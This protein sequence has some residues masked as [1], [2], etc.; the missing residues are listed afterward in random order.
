MKTDAVLRQK[1]IKAC[2]YIEES[3]ELPP[4]SAV[5]RQAALSPVY[6]QKVFTKALGV[7]P[8]HYA[9]AVRF[10]R[11]RSGLKKGGD[12]GR[13]LYDAGFGGSSRLYEFA[14]RYL[15]MTPRAYQ[16]KGRG[17]EITY[18]LANSP[19]GWLLVAATPKGICFVRPGNDKKK[20][21][22]D[23]KKEFAAASL[24]KSGKKL[25]QWMQALVTYLY[26][27]GPWPLLPYDVRATA[28][29]RR[30]WNFL[31]AIPAG[32]TY[33]YSAAAKAMGCPRA[34]RAVARAC[35]TNNI[36]LVIPCHRI[37]PKAGGVGGYRWNPERKRRLLDLEKRGS[38]GPYKKG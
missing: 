34:A 29:Q 18:A 5:A 2:R 19:L 32:K 4:L 15:G 38:R 7:S 27:R 31:Q 1:L 26:G 11:L 3:P 14:G 37:V 28:F 24:K 35:A 30:V 25:Q 36:C 17:T 9:D 23:F 6:F 12:V 13:A 33:S 21:E 16:Q 20:L 10:K 8:R 22:D